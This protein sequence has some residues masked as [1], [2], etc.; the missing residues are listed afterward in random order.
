MSNN[1]G[2]IS[3]RIWIAILVFMFMGSVAAS[4]ETVYFSIFLNGTVFEY[5]SMGA[6]ITL[7]D[8]VNLVVSLSAVVA[9]FAALIMGTLSEKMKNRKAFISIGYIVWGIVTVLFGLVKKDNISTAF[10]ISDSAEIITVTAIIAVAF[11]LVMAFLRSTSNDSVFQAWLTDVTTPQISTMIETVF[12]IMGFVGTGVVTALVARAQNGKT[13]YDTTFFNFGVLAIIFGILG[14]YIIDNP[15]KFKDK[16]QKKVKSISLGDLLYG[17]RP[18]VIKENLNLYLILSSGC[19]FNTAI[20][21]FFPY[22]FI[23]LTDVVFPANKILNLEGNGLVALALAAVTFVICVAAILMAKVKTHRTFVF[24][25]SVLCLVLG[26]LIL[27]MTTHIVGII[28]GVPALLVGYVIIMIEFGATVRIN[29]PQDKVGL[30]QGVRMIFLNLIPMLVGPTLGNIAAKNS[31]F[32]FVTNGVEKVLP[33]EDM[34]L[35]AAIVSVL[36]FI[37]MLL[38]LKRD[39]A[40]KLKEASEEITESQEI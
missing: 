11:A 14:F 5:G 37:P 28:A 1:N 30:F 33:T 12:T 29:I 18:R 7:T 9:A 2:R 19:L 8:T 3:K 24:V 22:L 16:E 6:K 36:I 27:S 21:V 35:Y 17:F 40:K 13:G 32:T 34:F 4:V 23:Y 38:F 10:G 25:T 39:N 20:Q 15:K 31:A 26:L